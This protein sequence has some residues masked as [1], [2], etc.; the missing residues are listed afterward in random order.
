MAYLDGN[1][2]PTFAGG[3]SRYS[4]LGGCAVAAL[5][6]MPQ[7]VRAQA[8][9]GTFTP[10]TV[11]AGDGVINIARTPNLDTIAINTT[12]V[13]P[14]EV[15]AVINWTPNDTG[16]GTA[17]IIFLPTGA[18]ANFVAGTNVSDFTILNRIIPTGAAAARGIRFD[19][20]ITSRIASQPGGS[21]FF[22]SPNGIIAGAGS[23]FDVGNLVLTASDIS[24]TSNLAFGPTGQLSFGQATNPN[25]AITIEAGARIDALRSG[26]YVALVAPQIS[27]GG[28]VFVNGSAVYVAAEAAD[29]YIQDRLFGIAIRTGT[30]VSNAITH[31]GSTTSDAP[32][33]FED[34]RRIY[35]ASVAK[36]DAITMLVGGTLG[37]QAATEGVVVDGAIILSAGSGINETRDPDNGLT[38]GGSPARLQVGGSGPVDFRNFTD[39]RAD[40][41]VIVT[42]GFGSSLAF[43]GGLSIAAGREA[44]LSAGNNQSITVAGSAFVQTKN[45]T[46]GARAAVV[47]TFDPVAGGARG[48]IAVAGDLV[49]DGGPTQ[50]IGG[51]ARPSTALL[52]I[53]GGSVSASFVRVITNSGIFDPISLGGRSTVSLSGGGSLAA[54]IL[55]IDA[56]AR[57]RV[58][59]EVAQGGSAILSINDATLNASFVRLDASGEGQDGASAAGGS[60]GLALTGGTVTAD[61]FV[62]DASATIAENGGSASAAGG[63]VIV[64]LNRPNL[65]ISG[66]LSLRGNA[67]IFGG[68]EGGFG[69]AARGGG[70]NP[71]QGFMSLDEMEMLGG[72]SNIAGGTISFVTTGGIFS[73]SSFSL[74]GSA[75]GSGTNANA[76]NSAAQGGNVELIAD[77]TAM[78]VAAI[79][80]TADA[81]GSDGNATGGS[82]EAGSVRVETRNGAIIVTNSGAFN[83]LSATATAGAGVIGGDALGGT[84]DIVTNNGRM[85]LGS[86]LL[87]SVDAFAGSTRVD[88]FG[89]PLGVR[90][91][92][93]RAG[94]LTLTIGVAG[95]PAAPSHFEVQA[96]NF[97]AVSAESGSG[98]VSTFS[99]DGTQATAGS[100]TIRQLS[101]FSRIDN[102]TASTDADG[103]SG[104]QG[105]GITDS[106]RGG[107]ARAGNILLDISSGRADW[108]SITASSI[109]NGGSGGDGNNG[110]EGGIAVD[111]GPG[112]SALA[113]GVALTLG[114]GTL[115][116][117]GIELR[118]GAIGGNGGFAAGSGASGR[119]GDASGGTAAL[120]LQGLASLEIGYGGGS[121]LNVALGGTNRGGDGESGGNAIGGTTT[122]DVIG[123]AP[124]SA[125]I[126]PNLEASAA[127]GQGVGAGDT[128]GNATGGTAALIITGGSQNFSNVTVG[129]EGFGGQGGSESGYGAISGQGGSAAGGTASVTTAVATSTETIRISST[130]FGGDGGG[131]GVGG[132]AELAL[133]SDV[134]AGDV[135]LVANGSGGQGIIGSGSAPAGAGGV[136]RGGVV[137]FLRG[138]NNITVSVG[139]VSADAIGIGGRGGFSDQGMSSGAAAGNAFGGA[140]TLGIIGGGTNIGFERSGPITVN[141]GAF[142][143]AGGDGLGGGAGGN[144]SAGTIEV[145][146]LSGTALSAIDYRANAVGGEGGDGTTGLGGSGGNATGGAILQSGFTLSDPSLIVGNMRFDVSA[147]GGDAGN[148]RSAMGA[149]SGTGRDG[150]NAAAGQITIGVSGSGTTTLG[151]NNVFLADAT[152]GAGGSGLT[153]STGGT[154]G[155]GTGGRLAISAADGATLNG[156]AFS[157]AI[158]G[159]GGVGGSGGTGSVGT[160]GTPGANGADGN[161]ATDPDG[162]FGANGTNGTAGLTGGAGGMGG[163]GSGGRFA[164]SSS[165]A[166]INF[167]SLTLELNGFGATGGSGGNGGTGGAGGAGG[168]GGRGADNFSFSPSFDAGNGGR[169]GNGGQGGAAGDGG[170][171]GGGGFGDGGAV[172]IDALS[173]LITLGDVTIA[174]DGVGSVSGIAGEAGVAGLGGSAGGGGLGG[175]SGYGTNGVTGVAGSEGAIGDAGVRGGGENGFA[176]GNGGSL[177]FLSEITNGE[178]L[179]RIEAGIVQLISNG[180]NSDL[181]V[182]GGGGS[183][184]L[185]TN[186][187]EDQNPFVFGSLDIQALGNS[188]GQIRFDTGMT[189]SLI[190]GDVVIETTGDVLVNADANGGI[191]VGGQFRVDAFGQV[192]AQHA[193]Q[194]GSNDTITAGSIDIRGF[195]GIDALVGTRLVAV[196]DS[197]IALRADFGSISIADMLS[198]AGI[199]VSAGFDAIVGKS[200]TTGSPAAFEGGISGGVIDIRAGHNQFFSNTEYSLGDISIVDSLSATGSIALRAGGS[201]SFGNG[202]NIAAN[203]NIIAEA[204]D[205]ISLNDARLTSA[206]DLAPDIGNGRFGSIVLGAGALT[207][208]AGRDPGDVSSLIGDAARLIATGNTATLTAEAISLRATSVEADIVST[209][210]VN[211]PSTGIAARDDSGLLTGTCLEGDLCIG[212]ID[213]GTSVS[214]GGANRIV[215]DAGAELS[216]TGISLDARDLI[217]IGGE[218]SIVAGNSGLTVQSA[219]L[220]SFGNSSQARSDS[221]ISITTGDLTLFDN[222]F[223]SG[224]AVDIFAQP[225]GSLLG[226]IRLAEAAEITG[227]DVRIFAELGFGSVTGANGNFTLG[228]IS[229]GNTLSIGTNGAIT[230]AGLSSFNPFNTID[231][232]GV[233]IETG[234][235]AISGFL[236]VGNASVGNGDNAIRAGNIVI[237][238]ASASDNIRF[239]SSDSIF[240]INGAA[241]SVSLVAAGTI[242]VGAL[243][244]SFDV[245]ASGSDVAFATIGSLSGTV[246]IESRFGGI[247]GGNINA[248][249]Q[250]TLL[251]AD[252]IT[253][254]NLGSSSASIDISAPGAIVTGDLT[255]SLGSVRLA[256]GDATITTG[257]IAVGNDFTLTTQSDL[258][259]GG[260]TVGDDIRIT[261]TGNATLGRLTSNATG[262]DDDFDLSNII[263]EIGGNATV[264]HADSAND[265]RV[266]AARFETGVNSIVA[267]GDIVINTSG[268]AVLGNSTAGQAISVF[269]GGDISFASLVAGEF[270]NLFGNTIAGG[271][272]TSGGSFS[273][274]GQSGADVGTIASGPTLSLSTSEGTLSI[275]SGISTG[276]IDLGGFGASSVTAGT[277][278]ADGDVSVRSSGDALIGSATARGTY[279]FDAGGEGGGPIVLTDGNVFVIAGGAA[280]LDSASARS[281]IGITGTTI[282]GTGNWNAGED[283]LATTPGAIALGSLAAGNEIDVF[284][285]GGNIVT[286][287]LT[288]NGNG[289]ADR[290][291]IVTEGFFGIDT[292]TEPD[293]SSIEVLARG[294]GFGV[295]TA[296]LMGAND[297]I[298]ESQNAIAT[299]NIVANDGDIILD[300]V[301]G[302]NTGDLSS[303][304]GSVSIA[305]VSGTIATG[306]I[307]VGND[308]TL[309]T[310]SDLDLAGVSVGDDIR[311]TTSGA[312]TFGR[313][314][315]TGAGADNDADDS[316]IV[317]NIGGNVFV[318]HAESANDFTVRATR[319]ET[320]PSTIITEGDIDIATSEDAILGN[321][322]AGGFIGVSAG[323]A[324][325]FASLTA[326]LSTNLNG[327][328]IAGG[329]SQSGGSFSAFS[330][331]ANGTAL[332]DVISGPSLDV[333][334]SQGTLHIGNATTTGNI[335]I[336]GE[337]LGGVIAGALV[338]D[339]NVFVE[340]NGAA[341]IMSATA[342]GTFLIDPP[343]ASE[344]TVFVIA[345]G[346]ATLNAA[347]ARTMIGI[348]GTSVSGSGNWVAGEDILVQ[349]AGAAGLGALTAG[350]D[351]IIDAGGAIALASGTTTG[352]A[353]DNRTLSLETGYGS[354]FA[355]ST[356]DADGSDVRLNAASSV[357]AT[358]VTASDDI[359]ITATGPVSLGTVRSAGLF[360]EMGYGAM[361][362]GS[363][364]TISTSGTTSVQS[365]VEAHNN[366]SINAASVGG[367]AVRAGNDVT[368]ATPGA[369]TLDLIGGSG[370]RDGASQISVIAPAGITVPSFDVTGNVVLTADNGAITAT[371]DLRASGTIDANGRAIALT[372]LSGLTANTLGA[373]AG[374]IIVTSVGN[375]AVANAQSR[376]DIRLTSSGADVTANTLTTSA[377]FGNPAATQAGP[378]DIII[379]ANGTAD[380]AGP[381][382]ARR[383][384]AATASNI[385]VNGT[386]L[387][388]AISLTSANIVVDPQR[389]QI[390][391]QGRT[392]S[393]TFNSISTAGTTIGGT[394]VSTGYSLTNAE[395][396]R[397][398][399][400]DIVIVTGAAGGGLRPDSQVSAALNDRAP[401]VVLDT[402]TLTGA[403]GQTGAMAGNIGSAGRLRIETS[404]KLRT[405][406]AVR[407]NSLTSN[408][409]FEILASQAI[410]IDAATGSISLRD[411]QQGLAGTLSLTSEDVVAAQLGLIPGIVSAATTTAASNLLGTNS[412]PANDD[413]YLR[414]NSIVVNIGNGFFVQNSGAASTNLRNFDDRRGLTVG[415][416]GLRINIANNPLARIIVNGRQINPAVTGSTL[417]GFITGIDFLRLVSINSGSQ[418]DPTG[419]R[420]LFDPLS[421]ING[422]AILNI[423]SCSL[424]FDVPNIERDVIRDLDRFLLD[425]DSPEARGTLRLPF[426]LIQIRDP[427]GQAFQPVID[428]PV[429]GSGNDDL[430]AVDDGRLCPEGETCP[431]K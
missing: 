181:G 283:I 124:L 367:A 137:R 5:A 141:V 203:N 153:G 425:E 199:T 168:T 102:L 281:M 265:F 257:L 347:S 90:G 59:G 48:N 30:G 139:S 264:V 114:S 134:I 156:G 62:L 207:D 318:D 148:S 159:R 405:T 198:S 85:E 2:K 152:G 55:D 289:R 208:V 344:G 167:D 263:L 9:D 421:T 356:V 211:A 243:S 98:N 230:L 202:A 378:G 266:Q 104:S 8:F 209:Q 362:D 241:G 326:G 94:T 335:S 56:G 57:S 400:G 305:N 312:A 403:N 143:E 95:G 74:S 345:D 417:P 225:A 161:L 223:V 287:A 391:A 332:G 333:F 336:G 38:S 284:A 413:G 47:S 140:A 386:A 375:L 45:S 77:G 237:N 308:F 420:G 267:E 172:Q 233:I 179:G 394:G 272:S 87:V 146:G 261:T 359:D 111:A 340:S 430:W 297:V 68:G 285:D 419:Q 396:Q 205:N 115:L 222:A 249:Q 113:G 276:D 121:A 364:I 238:D 18:T 112:G 46:D 40:G 218:A 349:T 286:G 149:G 228:S 294:T 360:V 135:Q 100:I 269:A 252:T 315:A 381:L 170:T 61:N 369:V 412:L 317:L 247:R 313:L 380:L 163:N 39:L 183:V 175:E 277:L 416:G 123:T 6:L 251:S 371:T 80:L 133:N 323:G 352:I 127:G 408:N 431:P 97:N 295:T 220:I 292:R 60:I 177:N 51:V 310:D 118:Y 224:D 71:D 130:A 37:Y 120:T 171:A 250:V 376:G 201:I 1:M 355:I 27:Q 398:F 343:L 41:D 248:N 164:L 338:A 188:G 63:T 322:R 229:A 145:T 422:C 19:G 307:T 387:G 358:N 342:R 35:M 213:G 353:R 103:G 236:S 350:D 186:G 288:A 204:G 52:D 23:V 12:N 389:A 306:I 239:E 73:A 16:S 278:I 190:T 221:T 275:A 234:T 174:A 75:F 423:A 72:A 429:T 240:L 426:M 293:G 197:G 117:N 189:R 107:G 256:N 109:A 301:G 348:T 346:A 316:N 314:I 255:A 17:P 319:F 32:V 406:G 200:Q 43:G 82:A 330:F 300:A 194:L 169:G 196:G 217:E 25:A 397:A 410:E 147:S 262:E 407:L 65:A 329:N 191:D 84:I 180:R 242:E 298:V 162:Q 182:G 176:F 91:G 215:V 206:I 165:Q 254:S 385:A 302:I 337:G 187:P 303:L 351:L 414:A 14:S 184:S 160:D 155:A 96:L 93:G 373:T 271:N 370:A 99:G 363:N 36:N 280:R 424:T 11:L 273:A 226:Q 66:N 290:A 28:N 33:D 321:S 4:L 49:V 210:I 401:D 192:V 253:T 404:G 79:D 328:S 392:S 193:N 42:P 428:D 86:E 235:L 125:R 402:L 58:G 144:A 76:A 214:L 44:L 365:L 299:G 64:G 88:N 116:S 311:I 166:R 136:G 54:S 138:G 388:S 13:V 268:D 50:F 379:T 383:N 291:L 185:T 128:G 126:R 411:A 334:A 357:I 15:R 341:T 219:G 368:I 34:K 10:P 427:E 372:S 304:L 282:S 21:V 157:F 258:D 78:S 129:A 324:I 195:S 270:V 354:F 26:S 67:S 106:G 24:L 393:V 122:L 418:T 274:F 245:T 377:I 409:R 108:R 132:T 29:L 331:G 83:R 212:S 320:G 178:T 158:T 244:A 150:G 3:S 399:A 327:G 232:N 260:I 7:I 227:V 395:L 154:G 119:G 142:A 110:G 22:Y 69:P 81:I 131:N 216:A 390:G 374:D 105:D 53:G 415:S 279:S 92:D 361:P 309:N 101:G 246:G 384:I 366:L 20:T 89:T 325:G 31:T 231:A 296:E 382:D 70:A 151:E 173:G 339:G 259:F